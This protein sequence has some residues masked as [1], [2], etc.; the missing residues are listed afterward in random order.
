MYM[1]LCP[2][3]LD[4]CWRQQITS[5]CHPWPATNNDN[6]M[7]GQLRQR[8][9]LRQ[10][11]LLR[12]GMRMDGSPAEGIAPAD[13]LL[14]VSGSHPVRGALSWT[15]LLQDSTSALQAAAA[16]RARGLLP[17][18]T[19]L[20]AVANPFRD[21]PGSLQRKAW[22]GPICIERTCKLL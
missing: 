15:G 7:G 18:R 21:A 16:L 8:E 19:A 13:A 22:L 20:W 6:V 1:Q 3:Q 9:G 14:L 4:V 5:T 10:R 12:A 2:C 11:I 17:Q